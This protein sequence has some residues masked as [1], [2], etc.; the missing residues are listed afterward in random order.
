MSK[1]MMMMR[2][3]GFQAGSVWRVA[4]L[5][6]FAA[7][8][9]AIFLI[10]KDAP[11]VGADHKLGTP[12]DLTVT[13]A[14]PT[15][16][17]VSWRRNGE[18]T[19]QKYEV[20][21]YIDQGNRAITTRNY[22]DGPGPQ[23]TRTISGL[24]SGAIYK[25]Q[26]RSGAL[27]GHTAS[28]PSELVAV[29]LPATPVSL[30]TN[31]GEGWHGGAGRLAELKSSRTSAQGFRTGNA[32]HGYKLSS[33]EVHINANVGETARDNLKAQVWS[34]HSSY[35]PDS[36]LHDLTVPA[37]PINAG[38]VSFAAPDRPT[39][40]PNT[41]YWV[42][43]YSTTIDNGLR[44]TAS[45][46]QASAYGWRIGDG[47]RETTNVPPATSSTW[48]SHQDGNRVWLMSVKG[49]VVESNANLAGLSGRTSTDGS[50][51]DGK[52]TLTP[53][54]FTPDTTSY[55]AEVGN[56]IT[57]VKLTPVAADTDATVTVEGTAV[58]SGTVSEAIA[59]NEDAHALT[60]RVTAEDGSTTRD[61]T[62]TVT[63]EALA[64]PN[65]TGLEISGTVTRGGETVTVPLI[66]N[67]LFDPNTVG[68][69]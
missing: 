39:L 35:Y 14:S 36:K 57:H 25:F 47:L 28:D 29:A 20:S 66:S 22:T 58:D 4:V 52:L 3:I 19:T 7:A 54:T 1:S 2:S 34:N 21:F 50:T 27:S 51:F 43:I 33:V 69:F 40:T 5:A 59:L 8:A 48:R 65:L 38:T 41:L 44:V 6:V 45:P 62:V 31:T 42:V 15:S 37:H 10:A 26:I 24:M 53:S 64:S 12:T 68:L 67:P 63:R 13:V 49:T 60:V 55:T 61:Y 16:V 18:P 56:D 9:L 32:S 11:P 30:V 46:D 23:F 17:D